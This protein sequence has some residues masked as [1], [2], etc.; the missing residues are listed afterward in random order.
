M[1]YAPS[2]DDWD[3]RLYSAKR[4]LLDEQQMRVSQSADELEAGREWE[5]SAGVGESCFWESGV[6]F[7]ALRI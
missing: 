5:S 4:K 7:S 3:A 1:A 2:Q 6:S